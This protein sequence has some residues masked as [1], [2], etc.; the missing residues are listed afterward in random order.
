MKKKLKRKN[1]ER[2]KK[3]ERNQSNH[4]ITSFLKKP[5]EKD[6]VDPFILKSLRQK[7]PNEGL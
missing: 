1:L 6:C 5:Y 2:I 4:E 7:K 3:A